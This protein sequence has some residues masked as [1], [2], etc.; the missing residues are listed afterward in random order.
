MRSAMRVLTAG[1]VVLLLAA[2]VRAQEVQAGGQNPLPALMA[3]VTR[4]LGDAGVPFTPE[5]ERAIA[6]MMEERRQSAEDLFG[7]LMDFSAGPTS[8]L[9]T[10]KL[11]SAIA[12]LRE[13]FLA[14][15]PEYLTA[16]QLAAWTGRDAAAAP[17]GGDGRAAART[18]YVRI[19]NNP[20][21][22]ELPDYRTRA[23]GSTEVIQRGGVGGWHGTSEF[24]LK[25]DALDARNAFAANK[26]LYQQRRLSV[27]AGGPVVPGRFTSHLIFTHTE[28][29]N[30]DTIHA[31]LPDG[32]F[33][34]GI[35]RP[36]LERSIGTRSTYQIADAHSLGLNLVYGTSSN[37]NEQT[38]GFNLPERAS[39]SSGHSWDVE[40]RHFSALSPVSVFE[41]RFSVGSE[42]DATRPVTDAVRIDVLDAFG[43]GGAQNTAES[44]NRTY[45]V[46]TLYT[47]L[48][49]R[50]TLKA[51][52]DATLRRQHSLSLE[53]FGGTFTFSSPDAY[54]QGTPL[55]YSV[56]AGNPLLDMS[57]TELAAFA[58]HDLA[59]SPR[60]ML[61]LGARY[62]AQTNVGDRNNLAPRVGFAYA[63]APSTVVRGGAGLFHGRV[64][65]NHIATQHRLDG[66]RQF[67]T[68]I[69]R[70]SYPDPFASGTVRNRLPSVRVIDPTLRNA[71][72]ALAMISVEQSLP[73]NLWVSVLYDYR[74]E[75]G[76]LRLR[77]LN[78]PFDATATVLRSCQPGQSV[79][80]CVRPD[81]TR[82][83]VLNLES[84]GRLKAHN[85]RVNVRQRF[86]I[87]TAAA[88][89]LL[90]QPRQDGS[91]T[92][93]RQ[94]SDSYNPRADWSISSSPVHLFS[95]TVNAG[96]PGGIFLTTRLSAHSGEHYTVTTGRD[97]NRDG[98]INDRPA[99]EGRTGRNGPDYFN[100]DLNLSKA[101]FVGAGNGDT[102]PNVNV[103][104]N[105]VNA[106]NRV[107]Y[108]PPSGVL[109]SPNF[110]RSTSA[111]Q[112]REI[113]VGLRFQF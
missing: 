60:L 50:L 34:L 39:S 38:G 2:P 112:P 49:E 15:L 110:G 94:P 32:L 66:A 109:T 105:M 67:E 98:T 86:S 47:R 19:Q 28:S 84:T 93:P 12:W 68:I 69:D 89:Y 63:A 61:M 29:E 45:G 33:A 44:G 46:G 8:G 99:G 24:L 79:E 54:V 106:L 80:T 81:P 6:L 17:R 97:D 4:V 57:Q 35:T 7:D 41:S 22:A 59:L 82:G 65:L 100:V 83:Q 74:R 26:P 20:F 23:R 1:M 87:F 16:A 30:V 43:I 58:Q 88:E 102:R 85:L 31:T 107:H 103:F 73:A 53:N 64:A 71:A 36:Q 11:E 72:M 48:G 9:Q 70:P 113:E 52:A 21:T 55:L 91:P 13:D 101:F 111:E 27:D 108:G 95:G 77:N 37:R 76:R 78:A 18:Q 25:D 5:Q 51:G 56:S 3:E 62:E 10:E 42:H 92:V 75:D 14:R 96:L 40:A 104:V 90:D